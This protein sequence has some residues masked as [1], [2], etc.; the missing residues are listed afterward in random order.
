MIKNLMGELINPETLGIKLMQN[1]DFPCDER[2]ATK[3]FIMDLP[4]CRVFLNDNKN[5]PWVVLVP[6]LDIMVQNVLGLSDLEYQTLCSEKRIVMKALAEEFNET[7]Q[8]NAAEFSAVVR[9]FHLH[10]IA[11]N[12]KDVDW[13]KSVFDSPNKAIKYDENEKILMCERMK[14]AINQVING[15]K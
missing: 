4:M 11:R 6:R 10:L 8:L 7:C 5:F 12:E 2:L 13:P 3:P 9:Q 1:Y 15:A 14:N